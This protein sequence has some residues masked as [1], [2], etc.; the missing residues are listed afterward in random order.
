MSKPT[1]A[2][3]RNLAV[4]RLGIRDRLGPLDYPRGVRLVPS[5]RLLE[6]TSK[7]HDAGCPKPLTTPSPPSKA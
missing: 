7:T 1:W 3:L 6:V 5:I 4:G 2:V